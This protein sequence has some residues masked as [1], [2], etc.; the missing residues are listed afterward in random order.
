[1]PFSLIPGFQ[2]SEPQGLVPMIHG[3]S[4]DGEGGLVILVDH[5][6][7]SLTHLLQ[8][9]APLLKG[10]ATL[11]LNLHPLIVHFPIAFLVG[12]LAMDLF[13]LLSGRASAR[14]LGTR[15]L[16]LGSFS[17]LIALA[18]GL[19]AAYTVPHDG[20]SHE[21]MVWH[22]RAGYL[23]AGVSG[24]LSLIHWRSRLPQ[25]GMLLSFQQLLNI[26]LLLGLLAG[27]DLGATLVYGRGVAVQAN[28][29]SAQDLRPHSQTEER[30]GS[31]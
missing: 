5:F 19:Y 28:N 9:E 4:H 18:S 26:V 3:G 14:E 24:A 27:G 30:Q 31:R 10:F 21:L 20:H 29:P 15:L 7:G 1:M 12:Y 22:Q 23:I 17:A 13:G 25:E 16:Y 2:L 11:G 8:G 6:L